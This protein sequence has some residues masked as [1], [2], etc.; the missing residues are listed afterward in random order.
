MS[1]V[2]SLVWAHPDA[3]LWVAIGST[4]EGES[5]AGIVERIGDAYLAFDGIGGRLGSF[6]R[7]TDA[8][9]AVRS[10]WQRGPVRAPRRL[11]GTRDR[12]LSAS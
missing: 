9:D 5:H 3:R 2:P 7:R 1:A 6:S 11:I 10:A 4:H 8:E 12:L